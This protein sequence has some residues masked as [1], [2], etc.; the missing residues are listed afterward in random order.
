MSD[1]LVLTGA[2]AKGAFTAG[3]LAVLSD[4]AVNRKLGID[5]SRIVG[6]SSG[7]LN[8]VYYADAIRSGTEAGAGARLAQI[9]V[10]HATIREAVDINLRDVVTE[11]GL[12]DASKILALLRRYV[13]PSV[14]VR[15]VDLRLVVT[16]ADGEL[17]E[18]GGSPATT[19]EHVVAITAGDFATDESIERVYQAAAA[20]A[21]LPLL[22][23]PVSLR[24]DGC[25]VQGLDGGLLNEAPLG[26]A[27]AD[28]PEVCRIFVILPFPRIRHGQAVLHGLALASHVFDI[29]V[30]Q[31]VLRD[32]QR[33][34]RKNRVL[35]RL[36]ALLPDPSQR[37]R[38]MEALG[39]AGRR[40]VQIV[41]VRPAEELAG[42][43]F[44]GFWSRE[45]RESY[46]RAGMDAAQQACDQTTASP[47]G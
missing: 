21:A 37:A 4:P 34:A 12:S 32:L 47:S 2:G 10:E 19:F 39:W 14:S 45:L 13:R 23:A 41:E 25:E 5:V 40:R 43:A 1:A 16:N 22:Y 38:V 3:A 27:L 29:V 26:L 28:A 6:T 31:H 17:T 11:R 30:R 20:S 24:L 18:A 44:S 8:G 46:V 9:W 42:D 33:V 36:E 15:D 7:A 35:E